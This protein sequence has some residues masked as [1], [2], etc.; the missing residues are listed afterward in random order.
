M[1]ET[2]FLQKATPSSGLAFYEGSKDADV[3]LEALLGRYSWEKVLQNYIRITTAWMV[4]RITRPSAGRP[5]MMSLTQ[6]LT[7][8]THVE[9]EEF[10]TVHAN[11]TASHNIHKTQYHMTQGHSLAVGY[12]QK[13]RLRTIN[14]I[15][16]KL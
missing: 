16:W 14:I 7:A 1:T 12:F 10:V 4:E 8:L 3:K 5:A 13:Y 6:Y 9:V 2:P 15:W 11:S